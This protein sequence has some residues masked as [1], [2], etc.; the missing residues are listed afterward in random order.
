M[1][2]W[3]SARERFLE[4]CRDAVRISRENLRRLMEDNKDTE[5]G[6]RHG[7]AAIRDAEEYQRQVPLS[8]YRD[9]EEEVARMEQGEERVLT[10]YEVKHYI[11]TS[12]STGRQKRIPL[13]KEAL[14]RC[15][16]PI[17]Y[18][19]YACIPGMDAGKYLHLSVLG[20]IPDMENNKPA[21]KRT[22]G[23]GKGKRRKRA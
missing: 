7:F 17:Y 8:D 9:Y 4:D 21:R 20:A 2:E 1:N 3:E 22:G 19:A 12:G 10:A 23:L 6:R 11:M 5:Y 13:T 18:A 16:S 14:G 15:I